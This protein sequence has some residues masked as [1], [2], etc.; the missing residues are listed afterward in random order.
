MGDPKK[1]RKKYSTPSHPWQRI[2]ID[3]ERILLREYGLKNKREIWKADS[4]QKKL[5]DQFKKLVAEKREQAD[6]E[7]KQ[8]YDKVIA[9]GVLKPES[10]FDDVLNIG[11]KDILNRRLQTILFLKN[12]ARSIKQA[13]QFIVHG[14]ICVAGKKITSPSY[15]VRVNE[16]DTVCFAENSSLK[17]EMHPERVA[18]KEKKSGVGSE[19]K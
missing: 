17:D 7:R 8:L 16:E 18:I 5:K 2:R 15:L 3:E 19:E 4:I 11:T 13:R 10:K 14:H 6:I 12:L 9:L 1:Q